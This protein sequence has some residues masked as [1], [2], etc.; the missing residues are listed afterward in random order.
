MDPI[1]GSILGGSA[2]NIAGGV[3][4]AA[5]AAPYLNQESNVLQNYYNSINNIPLPDL[6]KLMPTDYTSAG[7]YKPTME[8]QY[9][10]AGPNP[11]AQISTDPRLKVAQMQQLSTLQ[12]MGDT[13]ITPEQVA[14]MK[15][16]RAQVEGEAQSRQQAQLE[17][18]A[19]RGVGSSEAALATRII[20][21][22]SAANREGQ[23]ADQLAAEAY[24]NAL[25]AKLGAGNLA[26][27]MQQQQF[28][29]QAQVAQSEQQDR[30]EQFMAN[31]QAQQ[32]NVQASNQANMLN[33]QQQQQLRNANTNLT[34]QY[35]MYNQNQRPQQMF[36]NALSKGG[37]MG[38]AA[39][40]MGNFYGQRAGQV[41]GAA[42]GVGAGIGQMIGGL[43][44]YAASLPAAAGAAGGSTGLFAGGAMD[45][46]GASS[47]L[48]DGAMLA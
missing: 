32:R 3:I 26:T 16:L 41:A 23:S 35:Q 10:I 46:G 18:Q 14:E 17:D 4:G 20:G 36:Q 42:Q 34:N 8:G 9:N 47:L 45:A 27:S 25:Q 38:T 29:Q 1:L 2:A 43:G 44:Q 11:F 40:T 5:Q 31:M 30:L 28:G 24:K 33:L 13:G 39:G 22:Q 19:R 6:Q 15:A 37:A 21:G 12:K 7:T 48:A